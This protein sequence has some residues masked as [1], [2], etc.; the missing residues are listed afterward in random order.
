MKLL[1]MLTIKYVQSLIKK[2][3]RVVK[4][5]IQFQVVLNIFILDEFTKIRIMLIFTTRQIYV[6]NLIE[7]Y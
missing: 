5:K 2:I 4:V 6:T 3:K 1:V 7:K